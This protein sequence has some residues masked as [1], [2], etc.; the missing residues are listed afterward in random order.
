MSPAGLAQSMKRAVMQVGDVVLLAK[1][2]AEAGGRE[3]LAEFRH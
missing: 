3:G 1:P 2:V